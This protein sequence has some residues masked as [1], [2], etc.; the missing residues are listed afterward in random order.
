MRCRLLLVDLLPHRDHRG[1][2]FQTLSADSELVVL[3]IAGR[4]C[5]FYR[6][7]ETVESAKLKALREI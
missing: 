4:V 3:K 2:L 5:S 1:A 6:G 7:K